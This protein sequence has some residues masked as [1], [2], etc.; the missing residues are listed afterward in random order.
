MRGNVHNEALQ[1]GRYEKY[2]EGRNS[3]IRLANR[4][5]IDSICLWDNGNTNSYATS[6]KRISVLCMSIYNDTVHTNHL[7]QCSK[8]SDTL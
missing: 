4:K 5:R 6:F 7:V 3:M 2:G 1:A 8:G